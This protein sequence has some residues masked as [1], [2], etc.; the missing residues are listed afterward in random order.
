MWTFLGSPCLELSV[1][2]EPG[3]LVSFFRLGKFLAIIPSNMF[4][5]PS[6]LSSS[7]GTLM[8]WMFILLMLSKRCLNLLS[9][10]K[11]IS[12]FYS[13]AWMISIILPFISLIC[14]SPSTNLLILSSVFLISV[15]IF[16][17][18]YWFLFIFPTCW[19][20]VSLS[21]STLFPNLVNIF[22]IITLNSLSGICFS[23]I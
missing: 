22:M 16:F 5:V 14:F 4:S 9:F 15:V 19:L 21:S 7:S 8:V 20:K 10:L 17:N 1:L 18:S 12:S 23:F 11:I 2:L 6:F 3:C 13:S